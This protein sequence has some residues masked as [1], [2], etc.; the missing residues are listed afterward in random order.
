MTLFES[1]PLPETVFTSYEEAYIQKK[2]RPVA[3]D[4]LIELIAEVLSEIVQTTAALTHKD[5]NISAFT[6]KKLPTV[7]I[8]DYLSR[9]AKFCY[10]SPEAFV[11]ALIFIDRLTSFNKTFRL[12]SAN[13]HRSFPRVFS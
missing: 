8:K 2:T 10:C 5:A 11:L 3:L 4:Q 9:L 1:N 12:D 6:A 7:S 13:V